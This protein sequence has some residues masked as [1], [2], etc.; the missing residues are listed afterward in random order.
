MSGSEEK[1]SNKGDLPARVDA[2]NA[3]KF[4]GFREH[5]IPVLLAAKLLKPLGHPAPNGPK[6]LATCELVELAKSR[7]WLHKATEAIQKYWRK[8]N[9]ANGRGGENPS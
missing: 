7:E 3:A 2:A 8:K 4:L 6:H 9:D 5:D 1:H